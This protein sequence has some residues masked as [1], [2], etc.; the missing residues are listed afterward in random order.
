MGSSKFPNR[1]TRLAAGRA[2]GRPL[3][4]QESERFQSVGST[5]RE[6]PHNLNVGGC[7]Y[8]LQQFDHMFYPSN[9]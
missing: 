6:H 3:K 5:A 2:R 1:D 4:S 7:L 8:R 9:T